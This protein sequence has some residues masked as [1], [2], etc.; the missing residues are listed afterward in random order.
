MQHRMLLV[1]IVILSSLYMLFAC[2]KKEEAPQTQAAA[3]QETPAPAA[4][5]AGND[6]LSK[7]VA[8]HQ[9]FLQAY[10]G[11]TAG[12]QDLNFY[13]RRIDVSEKAH[14][15]ALMLLND[16]KDP[17]AQQF[18]TKFTDLLQKYSEAGRTYISSF[19]DVKKGEKDLA[20]LKAKGPGALDSSTQYMAISTL[21]KTLGAMN[22]RLH[23]QK[24]EFDQLGRE[25]QEL[26]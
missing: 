23:F 17:Q 10:A 14:A 6:Q 24:N 19:E 20:D 13:Q 9:A 21:E 3:T 16:S 5:P 12:V 25:L 26:K 2:S 8:A 1:S 7:A 18:L 15:D 22:D 4:A 11:V